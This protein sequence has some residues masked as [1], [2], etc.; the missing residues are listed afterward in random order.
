MNNDNHL[1]AIV[2]GIGGMGSAALY[3]LAV[4]GQRVLG[5]EQFSIGHELGSSHGLSRI[6]RM[7]Y[8]EDPS[9]VPLLRRSYQLWRDLEVLSDDSLLY[10]TGGLDIG[11]D[12]SSLLEG[13]L[14]SCIEHQL[15]HEILTGRDLG[16]R[17]PGFVVPN[18]FNAVYQPDAGFLVPEKC[19]ELY[20]A[21]AEEHGACIHQNEKVLD[22]DT[23]FDP[24]KITTDKGVYTSDVV[25]I[26]TGAWTAKL[27]PDYQ[28]L[29]IPER[30]VLLWTQTLSP[31]L[32][33][34]DKFPIFLM[35]G[36]DDDFDN[37]G[38]FYGYYGF[39]ELGSTG[40]KLGKYRHLRQVIDPD[41]MD[42]IPNQEDENLLRSFIE[43][44]LPGAAG[45]TLAMKA[46]IFTNTPDGHFLIDFVNK[47]K[48]NVIVASGFSGHG[49]KFA[50][51][52]GEIVADLS[53]E[54]RTNHNIEMF[55]L[56]RFL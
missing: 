46:C 47:K 37:E 28:K 9:Y 11:P 7:A 52:V 35:M 50:S 18:N 53:L 51:V 33:T 45:D 41:E 42:R 43:K 30:Q 38:H 14:K 29:A 2:I 56:E 22:I 17:F 25:V 21:M 8:F 15:Q 40:F 23:A 36:S 5:I 16:I 44:Y 13:S 39:P 55:K 12:G 3:Q 19:I 27:I 4:R 49:F 20:T 32:Y 26:T 48:K 34:P 1:D 54:K 10:I 24:V 6:I 31:E